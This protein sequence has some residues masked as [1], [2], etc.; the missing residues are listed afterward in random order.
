ME[1]PRW[2]VFMIARFHAVDV[3]EYFSR[4]NARVTPSIDP[5]MAELDAVRKRGAYAKRSDCPVLLN[6]KLQLN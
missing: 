4:S 2:S 5:R 1:L 6:A 3:D